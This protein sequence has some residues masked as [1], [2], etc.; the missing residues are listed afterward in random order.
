MSIANLPAIGLG[1]YGYE[2]E[3]A[4]LENV[5]RA[6]HLGYRHLDTAQ[7]YGSERQV[8]EAMARSPVPR[9][10]VYLATKVA[11]TNLAHE[12]VLETTHAS[13]DRLGVNFVDL[14][15][16]HWP[17]VTYDAEETLT[18]FNDLLAKGKTRHVGL[19]NV[20]PPLFEE[21]LDILDEP[22]VA[23]QVEM[24]PLLQQDELLSLAQ[25]H[26]VSLVAYCPLMRG[27]AFDTPKLKT[28]AD[29][30]GLTVAELCLA[31]LA[32]KPSVVPIPKSSGEAHLR[33][34]LEAVEI[35]LDSQ[36]VA[37]VDAIE[38]EQRVVDPPKGPWN[39]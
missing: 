21:A 3:S 17:S 6:L 22:P 19:G 20:S 12:D 39:W 4:C 8:G 33:E 38:R 24:H 28:I 30:A 29:E 31:W 32:D 23:I 2:S 15:Y 16:V 35:D 27:E 10:E 25:K 11:E 18:A 37:A 13:L 7:K 5:E 9:E 26:N 34:N 36:T 1:T 14:L